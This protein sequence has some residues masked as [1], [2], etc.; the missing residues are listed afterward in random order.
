L[1]VKSVDSQK[2]LFFSAQYKYTV[3]PNI[4]GAVFI[5]K[6]FGGHNLK[7][8]DAFI[9]ATRLSKLYMDLG[10]RLNST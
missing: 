9:S 5:F 4:G 1:R 6:D 10:V 3:P 8:N 7:V 2:I